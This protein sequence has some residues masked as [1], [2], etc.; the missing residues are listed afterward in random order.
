MFV[1][2]INNNNNH[3]TNAV[4]PIYI[5]KGFKPCASRTC[6]GASPTGCS[7]PLPR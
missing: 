2:L 5:P 6:A 1:V 4:G 7:P 3:E